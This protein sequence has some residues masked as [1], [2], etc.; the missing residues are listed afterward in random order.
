M[1]L[2]LLI[3]EFMLEKIKFL[4]LITINLLRLFNGSNKSW[5]SFLAAFRVISESLIQ[6]HS[7]NIVGNKIYIFGGILKKKFINELYVIDIKTM[8]LD[9]VYPNGNLP[10]ERAYH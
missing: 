7:M 9:V 2:A 6:G 1:S 5:I 4:R 3:I 10:V 8:E